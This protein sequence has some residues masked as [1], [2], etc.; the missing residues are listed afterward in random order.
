M[1]MNTESLGVC[2]ECE[3]EI[4]SAQVLI[5]Y[6]QADG[7]TSRFAECVACGTVVTPA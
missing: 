3:T 5:E 6:E 1:P 4:R 7:E 2:P